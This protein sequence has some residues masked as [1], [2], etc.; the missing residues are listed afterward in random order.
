MKS[1]THGLTLVVV[2]FNEEQNLERTVEEA[3]LV[4]QDLT[5]APEIIIVDDGSTDRTGPLADQLAGRLAWVHALHHD[6]NLGMGAALKTGYSAATKAYVT[7]LPG[8]GQIPASGLTALWNRVLATDADLVLSHYRKRRDGLHRWVLSKGLRLT[9]MLVAGTRVRS[10]GPYLVRRDV[11]TRVPLHSD[12]FFLNLELPIRASRMGL[13]IQDVELEVR[14]R[15]AGQSKVVS[16]R[17]IASVL[18]DLTALRLRMWRR[19][20]DSR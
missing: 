14:P 8:D 16:V 7:F 6:R 9:T 17:K 5:P 20:Q 2:A 19:H 15:Q 11:L 12:S 13:S 4:I 18:R 3:I 10:E 1:D